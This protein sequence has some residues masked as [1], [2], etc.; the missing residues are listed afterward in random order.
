MLQYVDVV[1]GQVARDFVWQFGRKMLLATIAQVKKNST[2]F[3]C[4][5]VHQSKSYGPGTNMWS[6]ANWE[7]S[8]DET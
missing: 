3:P 4:L 1:K 2:L 6:N 7:L 5:H 8:I